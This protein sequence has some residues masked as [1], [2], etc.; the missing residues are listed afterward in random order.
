MLKKFNEMSQSSYTWYPIDGNIKPK[1]DINYLVTI[2]K[3]DYDEEKFV[4]V[5]SYNYHPLSNKY[6]WTHGERTI[7]FGE[8]PEPYGE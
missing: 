8:L 5:G 6:E 3:N 4:T 1:I 7:A 2:Y